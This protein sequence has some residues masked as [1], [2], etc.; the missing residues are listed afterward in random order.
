MKKR[1]LSL[2]FFTGI[3]TTF[4]HSMNVSENFLVDSYKDPTG[5]NAEWNTPD[6]VLRLPR[7]TSKLLE[8]ETST[9][10]VTGNSER[11][12]KFSVK[13]AGQIIALGR[14]APLSNSENTTVHL[15]NDAG[16]CLATATVNDSAGWSWAVI[17]PVN[18]STSS[19]Y[20]VS[21]VCP[22]N[23]TLFSTAIP[24][25]NQYLKLSSACFSAGKEGFPSIYSSVLSGVAD[26]LFRTNYGTHAYGESAG[27]DTGA[28]FAKY[29]SYS[30]SQNL[31]SGTI[32]YFF[33]FS[34]DGSSWSSW[35]SNIA[36]DIAER[37]VKWRIELITPDETKSPEVSSITIYNNS[38][39]AAPLL[40]YPSDEFYTSLTSCTFFWNE[41]FDPDSS[42]LTYKFQLDDNT[43]F[44]SPDITIAG[45][46]TCTVTVTGLCHGKW[47]WRMLAKDDYDCES[48]W[49]D[50]LSVFVDTM[51]PVKTENL[52]ASSA[53]ENGAVKLRW[54]SP[55]DYTFNIIAEYSIFITSSGFGSLDEPGIFNI[56][57][58]APPLSPGNYESFVVSGLTDGTT[59][60]FALKSMDCA[61][62]VS[63]LSNAVSFLTNAPPD[64]TITQPFGGGVYSKSITV[65]WNVSDPNP[66]DIL[67]DIKIFLS[68]NSGISFQM[69]K[70]FS[71]VDINQWEWNTLTAGNGSTFRLKIAA[72][73]SRGL[74]GV[75]S[76]TGDF[77]IN[78]NDTPPSISIIKPLAESVQT[79]DA[80]IEWSFSDGDSFDNVYFDLYISSGG[81]SQTPVAEKFGFADDMHGGTTAFV[82]NTSGYPDG[83]NYSIRIVATDGILSSET[84]SG[85]FSIWNTNRPPLDFSLTEPEDGSTVSAITPTL[86]W[87][88]AGDPDTAYGDKLYWHLYIYTST[89]PETLVYDM[90]EISTASFIIPNRS[91]LNDFTTY[92]W[93]VE[94]EDSSG[95]VRHSS[96]TFSFYV[97]WS[98]LIF[99]DNNVKVYSPDLT[100]ES[101]LTAEEVLNYDSAAT[102]D[103]RAKDSPI[104]KL[105]DGKKYKIELKDSVTGNVLD[106]SAM[107]FTLIFSYAGLS[108]ISPSTVKV[109]RLGQENMWEFVENQQ[110]DEQ[111]K[112][113]TVTTAG[114]SYFR[115]LSYA[116]TSSAV[117]EVRNF[118]NP[119]NPPNEE[120]EIE[121]IL[122]G[123]AEMKF[124]IF[125][126]AG[127]LV[128]KFSIPPGLDGS[129]GNPT[130]ITN[131]VKWDGKNGKSRVVSSGIYILRVTAKPVSG[132]LFE[133]KRLIGVLK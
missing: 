66:E 28:E 80:E 41:A 50:S 27:Y 106:S 119:F 1:I 49:S 117:S 4:L 23:F 100:A 102:A 110:I 85:I 73:D 61:G 95:E 54:T 16:V 88:A 26:V 124:E 129:S 36:G 22:A 118:P 79:G 44:S 122:T 128:K 13:E 19:N 105:L 10:T 6:G 131:I 98:E 57:G 77:T 108:V 9:S 56:P 123:D 45:I 87:E 33:S 75:S 8:N 83:G 133:R 109:F 65:K 71:S 38:F 76:Q 58:P 90:S 92:F 111:K 24:F 130:G 101:Y 21:V 68:K 82:L 47:K 69:I 7:N 29:F 25:E 70:E 18:V 64:V 20:R 93:R 132:G 31:N 5:T 2:L 113:I 34:P 52:N 81:A 103:E 114:L 121:Y 30:S 104:M 126:P 35:Q 78:D 116:A 72:V 86:K 55:V 91:A 48:G 127:E 32:N 107:T 37:F 42:G 84:V 51:S 11:G 12:W 96:E 63:E 59:Y 43:D 62:N 115:I 74:E 39:P 14:F 60:F 99:D 120:T 15:W 97:R 40:I 67:C 94:A 46:S 89:N 53:S 3:L 17:P 112:E 125:S